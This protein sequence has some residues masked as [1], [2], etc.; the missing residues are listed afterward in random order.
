MLLCDNNANVGYLTEVHDRA[1]SSESAAARLAQIVVSPC[2]PW[3]DDDVNDNERM[4][5]MLLAP[6]HG[7][8]ADRFEFHN[9]A[10]TRLGHCSVGLVRIIRARSARI[11][12]FAS[13]TYL[14]RFEL[15]CQ[16][17]HPLIWNITRHS[18]ARMHTR[19][20]I[21][22]RLM[23]C[24]EIDSK[25]KNETFRKK[26]SILGVELSLVEATASSMSTKSSVRGVVFLFTYSRVRA[27]NHLHHYPLTTIPI[28]CYEKHRY[29]S[30]Q[31]F[32][33]R[34]LDVS[35]H[36]P[37]SFLSKSTRSRR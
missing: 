17:Y 16:L 7:I 32:S 24:R 21:Q 29:H 27:R 2:N 9:R 8:I 13:F 11:S 34:L 4:S 3:C 5:S 19:I 33:A 12:C 35:R 20:P 23:C 28:E 36:L 14:M 22:V 18:R 15:K 6:P 10:R 26:E 1:R 30:L 25:T 31:C 37:L